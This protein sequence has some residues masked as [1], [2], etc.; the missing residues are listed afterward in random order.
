MLNDK[1]AVNDQFVNRIMKKQWKYENLFVS[2][3]FPTSSDDGS[4]SD[5]EREFDEIED[6]VLPKSL[7]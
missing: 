4:G 1:S 3:E 7:R 5:Y 6:A 2:A